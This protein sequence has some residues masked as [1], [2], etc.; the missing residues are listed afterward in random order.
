MAYGDIDN[1][2]AL[3]R[4][5]TDNGQ[6]VDDDLY[7]NGG[8]NPS[9]T[10]VEAWLAQVSGVLDLAL[11]T[12]GFDVP[13]TATLAIA[14]IDALV[15]SLVVDLCHASNSTGRF[16]VTNGVD[17]ISPLLQ[18]RKELDEWVMLNAVG[19][20]GMGAS[21]STTYVGRNVASFDVFR[22]E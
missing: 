12:Q 22:A 1:V 17:N 6:F 9:K 5:W 14:A 16:A 8:T 15:E 13:V 4:V 19:I 11:A 3:A 2:A 7:G 21:K 18:I 20:E 10:Q